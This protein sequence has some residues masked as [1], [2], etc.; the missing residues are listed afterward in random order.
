MFGY[1][2]ELIWQKGYCAVVDY[3]HTLTIFWIKFKWKTGYHY[4]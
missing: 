1:K 4:D 2:K 3:E